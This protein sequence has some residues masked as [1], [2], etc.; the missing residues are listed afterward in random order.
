MIIGNPMDIRCENLECKFQ[1][2]AFV[3]TKFNEKINIDFTIQGIQNPP[4]TRPFG[5]FQLEILDAS[6]RLL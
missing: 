3:V 2:D 4:S 5:P 6:D 1:E